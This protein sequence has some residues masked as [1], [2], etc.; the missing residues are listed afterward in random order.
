MS[1]PEQVFQAAVAVHER[2][3]LQGAERLYR[4]VLSVQPR[5]AGALDMLG[6]L[7]IQTGN[8]AVAL[9]F[10]AQAVEVAPDRPLYHVHLGEAQRR[11]GNSEI[12]E[13]SFREAVRLAPDS[14]EAHDALAALLKTGGHFEAAAAE[15]RETVRLRPALSITHYNLGV[16]LTA[17]GKPDEAIECYRR[18]C[19]LQ[20]PLAEAHINLAGSLHNRHE[21]DA[22]AGEY[23]RALAIRPDSFE[24]LL[25]YGIMLQLVGRVDEALLYLDRALQVRP[26]SAL[27]HLN[28]GNVLKT[29][30]RSNEA[31]A[32][33]RHAAQLDPSFEAAYHNL[34]VIYNEFQQD[35]LALEFCEK[36]LLL[37]PRSASLC[38][39]K[40]M[41]LHSQ[42]RGDE[43]LAWYRKAMELD[44]ARP[45]FY[46]NRLYTF[47]YLPGFS[48]EA[49]FS[50]HRAW[51]ERFAEPLTH[52]AA[53]HER[54]PGPRH[55]LR[56]GYVSAYFR[57]HAVNYF[58]EP[59]LLAHDHD[60]FEVYCYSDVAA[61][62]AVTARIEAAADVWRPVVRYSDEQLAAQI[63]NDRIDILV[64]LAGHIGG[65]RLL[66]FARKPA[67]IQVTYI[68]YQN[69]TGMT[70]MDY[71]LTDER[72]D[73]PG[74]T[75]RY[76]TE[77]L[78]RLPRAFFC[79]RPPDEAPPIMP[80]PAAS[81]GYVTFG[82]FNIYRKVTPPV[83][84]AWLRILAGLENSRLL[85]L[86]AGGGCVERHLHERARAAS[87]D[88]ARIV[89]HNRKAMREYLGLIAEADI[90]LD[91]FPF[92][93]HTT[94]CDSIWM[95]VPVVMLEGES[96]ASRF[97][98]SVL[99][100]VGLADLIAQDIEGYVQRA[101]ALANDR[102]RLTRLRSTL[103]T[104][105][106]ASPLLDFAGFTR[107][108]EA[109]YRKMWNARPRTA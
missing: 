81:S 21:V 25:N 87:I 98:G 43:A 77:K 90:A 68:G 93:G 20:P 6:T 50:E 34:A 65:N 99:A 18:A 29:I 57:R 88:P 67:P 1:S 106:S 53:P 19:A 85:V 46:S 75:D 78:V 94:T 97:G 49:V 61:P 44:P 35:D 3:D 13:R 55:K 83:I 4:Q 11:T 27:A 22:A 47:N 33:Y 14:L 66:T 15:Y 28:R 62:D 86:A 16:V 51:A 63:R 72:A 41:A 64:D 105:M 76:Y 37:E 82:S 60:Q 10:F 70:A 7:A 40:G 71:R 103:R 32:E 8:A 58:S 52:L 30:R 104:T 80:L 95:G 5:H 101:L 84:D 31:I 39:L 26:G 17:L 79:Y 107:N 59:V 109:A 9:T 38:N 48:Q 91:P 54:D 89:L 74:L 102:E 100:N 96:Y 108:L 36:G 24:A 42:G 73:P 92:T 45:D 2:G 56:L 23:Q 69:T 12:A